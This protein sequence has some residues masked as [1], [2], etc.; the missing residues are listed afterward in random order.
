M[1]DEV[2]ELTEAWA[3]ERPDLDLGAISVFSRISRLA[4][5][6]LSRQGCFN[7]SP[8]LTASHATVARPSS[9][10]S[11]FAPPVTQV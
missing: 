3:R 1:R 6:L 8:F 7:V 10:R 4:R 9:P 2:D 11:L 5:P